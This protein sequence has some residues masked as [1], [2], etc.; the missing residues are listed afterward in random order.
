[1]ALPHMSEPS[2]A[3][4]MEEV[5]RRTKEELV[6][7]Y[8]AVSDLI[9]R[10]KATKE[11]KAKWRPTRSYVTITHIDLV[12]ALQKGVPKEVHRLTDGSGWVITV[13]GPSTDG[14]LLVVSVYLPKDDSPLAIMSFDPLLEN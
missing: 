12:N 1:M 4:L 7:L 10:L 3:A 8:P 2:P 13:N 9:G 11:R 5:R 6:A 14:M